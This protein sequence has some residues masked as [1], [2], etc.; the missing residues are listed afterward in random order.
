MAEKIAI[1]AMIK[2]ENYYIKEWI[3]YHIKIGFDFFLIYDN[4]SK[5]PIRKTV[6]DYIK[7]GI[8]KVIDFPGSRRGRQAEAYTDSIDYLKK[9]EWVAYIDLDEFIV[10]LEKETNIK[11]YLK[12]FDKRVSAICLNWLLFGSNGHKKIQKSVIKSFTQSCPNF[13]KEDCPDYKEGDY[14]CFIKTI[15]RPSRFKECINSHCFVVNK[16]N[17]VNV[18][19]KKIGLNEIRSKPSV[20]DKAMRINHYVTRS[21]EDFKLK[22]IRGGGNTNKKKG[23]GFYKGFQKENVQNYDI[24]NLLKRINLKNSSYGK[25]FIGGSG[26][27]G[28]TW[29]LDV[30]LN[31]PKTI[32]IPAESRLFQFLFSDLRRNFFDIIRNR[33]YF[34]IISK[35]ILREYENSARTNQGISRFIERDDLLN[36]IKRNS[37]RKLSKKESIKIFA[38]AIFNNCFMKNKG[39]KDDLF[40]EKTPGNI[41]Y[42][43]KI[44]DMYPES[45][46][47]E[48]VRD[49]RDVLLSFEKRTKKENWN[50]NEKKRRIKLWKNSISKGL[51]FRSN[52]KYSDRILLVKYE[53][54]VNDKE[55]QI[56]RIFDFVNL[57]YDNKLLNKIIKQSE[58]V[59]NKTYYKSR[60]GC[61]KE[62][63]SKEDLKLFENIAGRE[64]SIIDY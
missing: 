19:G 37:Y 32:G 62:N 10:L 45:K 16:G 13:V 5:I 31:H 11:D 22:N 6:K 3:D 56:K 17:V 48:I 30:L 54:L 35:R 46:F 4:G 34:Q 8:V 14:R 29:L 42:V 36:V 41:F 47:I 44:L 1:C 12:R 64:L 26:R 61:W 7:R 50:Q 59:V 27:C 53:D 33:S 39:N 23:Y 63:L 43:N 2:D 28:S 15:L 52:K 51:E 57:K 9:Y 25:L 38:D 49:G 20:I 24:I 58:R 55:N 21:Y 18:V 40:V 60:P